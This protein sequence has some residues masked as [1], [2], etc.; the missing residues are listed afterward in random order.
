MS[1]R[2]DGRGRLIHAPRRARSG[3]ARAARCT[4]EQHSKG[5]PRKQRRGSCDSRTPQKQ[6][7]M[8]LGIFEGAP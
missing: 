1:G 6:H 8:Q 4:R 5:L 3:A 7:S 2:S